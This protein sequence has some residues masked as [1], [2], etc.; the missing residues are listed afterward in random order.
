MDGQIR[1]AADGT[2]EVSVVLQHQTVVALGFFLIHSLGHA[3]QHTGI[4]DL[5]IRAAAHTFQNGAQLLGGGH[6]LGK[7]I[8]DAAGLQQSVQTL[9]L[10]SIGFLVHTVHEGDLLHAGKVGSA[11]VGQQHELFDHSF[12]LAGGALFHVDAVA[13][14]VEDQLHLAAL[15]IHAAALLAQAGTVAVQL[16]H[17]GQL[18]E[19]FMVLA[20]QLVVSTAGQQGVDLGVNTLD[21]AADDRLDKAV[22]DQVA[23]LIQMHQ[24]GEGQTQH[25]LIQ[26][27]D[28]VGKLLGQHGH[29]LIGIVDAGCAVK[30]FVVQFAAGL[31]IVGNICNVDTQ[32][33]AALRGLG[34]ADG[35]IDVLSLS[36][37]NGED[38]QGTQIHAALGVLFRDLSVLQLLGFLTNLIREAAADILRIE[39]SLCAALCFVRAAKSHGNAHAV[40]FLPIAALQDLHGHLVAVLCTA[41]AITHH[42]H[43]DGR[44]VVRHELQAAIN[45]AGSAHQIV[46]FFQNGQD[47]AF[48][49]AL[50]TGVLK[51][52][53]KHHVAGHGT[54]GKTARDKDIAGAVLQHDKGKILAQFYHLAQQS[55]V[56]T[57]G[58]HRKEHA[59]TLADDRLVHQLI[60]S[61]HHLAVRA[62]VPA[63]FGFEVFDGARL[64]LD[65]VLNFIAHCH[66][67]FSPCSSMA[68]ASNV[69]Q[70]CQSWASCPTLPGGQTAADILS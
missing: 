67:I 68:A 25:A 2:G 34:Q 26:A 39:Q 19:H 27:A 50:H 5:L 56:C 66:N 16:L 35:I 15:D 28:A 37:V 63:E 12:A 11:L 43:G 48:I 64:I 65:R 41:L 40:I 17:G 22:I 31:D 18:A 3:A 57:A 51:L 20:L 38:G 24:A 52:F 53:Y 21:A 59:L 62:A 1:V 69:P 70:R 55:L 6:I 58:A 23:I 61:L 60:H 13:V 9:Q 46:L 47:L 33:K 42:L 7:V 45:A 32:L 8:V 44:A 10:F 54:A 4:D 29:H 36:T 49:A 30:R 14:L